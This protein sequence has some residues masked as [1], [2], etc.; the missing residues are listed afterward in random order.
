MIRDFDKPTD[1]ICIYHGHCAD[2]FSGAWIV[3]K[4]AQKHGHVVE[5]FG[6]TYGDL[7]ARPP[8]N[9][10]HVIMVDF[11]YPAEEMI[12]I[13]GFSKSITVL[14]H[15]KT[16]ESNMKEIEGKLECEEEIIFDMNRSGCKIAW[17][18]FFPN[19]TAPLV[20]NHV[21]DRDLWRFALTNTKAI[22]SSVFSYEYT[23]EN[24][25]KL[26]DSKNY[27][28]LVV[29]GEAITRKHTKDI[30]ELYNSVVFLTEMEVDGKL[31]TIPVGNVPYTYSS[32]LGH[33]MLEKNDSAP[34]AV[35]YTQTK[36]NQ[37]KFSLRSMDDRED[38]SLIAK[39]FGGGGHRNAA[40]FETEVLPFV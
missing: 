38:V 21:E 14:D 20:L 26:M 35:C 10:R 23:F 9:M 4:W 15:H 12:K 29:Q 1:F 32:E 31:Y 36:Q 19:E 13:S 33:Y 39:T 3:N 37:F 40:G 27:T 2:G 7:D 28:D 34:F 17:D 24:W 11:S 18:Y 25:D 22:S 6:A 8:I 16:A 5:F 30:H